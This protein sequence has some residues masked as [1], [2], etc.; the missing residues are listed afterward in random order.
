MG[1]EHIVEKGFLNHIKLEE[2][3]ES[4]FFFLFFS[5]K[6]VLYLNDHWKLSFSVP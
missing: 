2:W 5:F 6:V 3:Q 4:L 1:D